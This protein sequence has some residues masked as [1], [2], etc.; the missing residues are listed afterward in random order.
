MIIAGGGS[1]QYWSICTSLT[2]RCTVIYIYVHIHWKNIGSAEV[3]YSAD[4]WVFFFPFS[5]SNDAHSLSHGG[6]YMFRPL[7]SFIIVRHLFNFFPERNA[8]DERIIPKTRQCELQR[9]PS[10]LNHLFSLF[11]LCPNWWCIHLVVFNIT[12]INFVNFLH[13]F[14]PL[15]Q[16]VFNVQC[17]WGRGGGGGGGVLFFPCW[18]YFWGC[19]QQFGL[20]R[21]NPLYNGSE[22]NV[23]TGNRQE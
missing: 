22:Q 1:L 15:Y 8:S 21:W 5:V 13:I 17:S 2:H 10:V 9:R 20:F 11:I 19:Q 6:L 4:W 3:Q 16:V 18:I 7:L 23:P 12:S 14:W